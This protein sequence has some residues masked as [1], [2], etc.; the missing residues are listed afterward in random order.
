MVILVY[1]R[2]GFLAVNDSTEANLL[3]VV[4]QINPAL[5]VRLTGARS[6]LSAISHCCRVGLLQE[7]HKDSGG[8][9]VA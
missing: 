5:S 8:N 9:K 1:G 6:C 7:L 4:E 2:A 3:T